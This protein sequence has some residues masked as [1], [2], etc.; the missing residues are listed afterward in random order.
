MPAV[1]QLINGRNRIQTEVTLIPDPKVLN[2]GATSSHLVFSKDNLG[3]CYS[4][5]F[6]VL[7]HGRSLSILGPEGSR[8]S[9][10]PMRLE[11]GWQRSS[12]PHFP[13]SGDFRQPGSAV[14][15]LKNCPPLLTSQSLGFD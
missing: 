12:L 13:S 3:H 14:L 10:A 15:P 4:V 8:A 1:T 6:L 2:E 5:P 7:K 9:S 11:W